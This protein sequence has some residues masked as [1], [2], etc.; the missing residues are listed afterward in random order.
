MSVGCG[1][2][3][4]DSSVIVFVI[5]SGAGPSRRAVSAVSRSRLTNLVNHTAT[6]F[7]N[8]AVVNSKAENR[9]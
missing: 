4:A 9:E 5:A 1:D 6:A 3:V 8:E 2:V 7:F